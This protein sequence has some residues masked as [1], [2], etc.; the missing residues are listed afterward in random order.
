MNSGN[1]RAQTV[2]L[3]LSQQIIILC[4][5]VVSPG[6]KV[7]LY[8]YVKGKSSGLKLQRSLS[9][10]LI[11]FKSHLLLNLI[12][13]LINLIKSLYFL[14]K[15]VFKLCLFYAIIDKILESNW[16]IFHFVINTFL[17]FSFFSLQCT[18]FLP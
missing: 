13:L 15:A 8:Y 18:K 5:N 16:K 6:F 14:V 10:L 2:K 9:S 12:N 17:F 3:T 11:N 1:F 4:F 7:T